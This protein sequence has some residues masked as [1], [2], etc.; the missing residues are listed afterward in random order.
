[1]LL[2]AIPVLMLFARTTPNQLLESIGKQQVLQAIGISIR[3]TLASLGIILLFGTPLAYLM[4]RH[5]FRFKKVLDTLID[6]PTILPPSVAGLA[7]LM[8]FG[9][10][11]P[12]GA[13]LG[14]LGIDIAFTLTAVIIAQTFIA[15]PFYVRAATIGFA[16][17]DSEIEQAAQ[18][19][20]ASRWQ[21]FQYLILPLSKFALISGSMMSWARALGEFGATMLFAGNFPGRTQTMPTAIYLGFQVDLGTALTL[22]VILVLISFGSLLFIKMLVSQHGD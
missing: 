13:W 11:G 6:L 12:F 5:Q 1:V 9:R 2:F 10:Q 16:S 14:R 21:I 18:L 19:D 17:V 3:T 15:A 7:L 8:T 22:S 20:G 4:A